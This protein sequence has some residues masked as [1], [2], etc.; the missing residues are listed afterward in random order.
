MDK[1]TITGFLLIAVVMIAFMVTQQPNAEQLRERK[2]IQD[3]I[4]Q[5]ESDRAQMQ[6]DL[7][8]ADGLAI[9]EPDV[10]AD[11]F[12]SASSISEDTTY[13][14]DNAVEGEA[15]VDTASSFMSADNN[16]AEED[17][18]IENEDLRLKVSTKGGWMQ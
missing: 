2:R 13:V 11:F 7:P 18:T 12:G 3:S 17:I 5:V 14:A 1:N 4:Q 9:D 8:K 6:A 15:V 10:V 16:A